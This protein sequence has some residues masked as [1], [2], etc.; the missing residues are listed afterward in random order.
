M[1]WALRFP[2]EACIDN[3]TVGFK[4]YDDGWRMIEGSNQKNQ[5]GLDD[6]LK[7]RSRHNKIFL[8]LILPQVAETKTPLF[9]FLGT[10]N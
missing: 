6:A 4:H 2:A 10:T 5:L 1:K 7:M 8:P 3:S 9:C